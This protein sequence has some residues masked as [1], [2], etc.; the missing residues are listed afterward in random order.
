M[1][2][3]KSPTFSFSGSRL[4]KIAAHESR[5]SDL[6]RLFDAEVVQGTDESVVAIRGLLESLERPI[7]RLANQST[8]SLKSLESERFLKLLQWL[9]P[10]PY[11]RHH[12]YYS[13]IRLKTTGKWLQNHP[14]YIRWNRSSSSSLLLIHGVRGSGKTILASAVVDSVLKQNS[15]KTQ[16][17]QLAYFYCAKNGF[18]PER[19]DPDDILRSLVRQLTFSTETQKNVY[20][21]LVIDY[22]R[23]EAEAKLDGFD[24]PRL[25]TGECIKM[26][27]D[28]TALNPLVLIIDAIDEVQASRR[29][30]LIDGLNDIIAKAANVVKVLLT[31]RN[32]SHIFAL[33]PETQR[34]SI[35]KSDNAGDIEKFVRRSVAHAI[36]TRRLLNGNVK[37]VMQEDIIQLLLKGAGEM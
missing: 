1:R 19:S 7:Y 31:T 37:K 26:I 36:E 28:L 16:H 14:E 22:E 12:E 8:M 17:A 3:V 35:L 29:H 11:S 5:L 15:E 24:V 32:D 4:R 21:G 13:E 25:R 6:A 20:E 33:L 27:L 10:V 30:E 2:V 18:E 23:R 34:I 9:S